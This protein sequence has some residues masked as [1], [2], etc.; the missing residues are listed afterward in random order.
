MI[1]EFKLLRKQNKPNYANIQ[2]IGDRNHGMAYHP[3]TAKEKY[4]QICYKV[5]DLIV[6]SIKKRFE[7]EIIHDICSF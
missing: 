1:N 5:I 3:V 6:E 7:Q 2:Q 4:R